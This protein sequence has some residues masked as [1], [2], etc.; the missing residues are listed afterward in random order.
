[1]KVMDLESDEDEE[2]CTERSLPI[3]ADCMYSS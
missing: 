1:M 3:T 2:V